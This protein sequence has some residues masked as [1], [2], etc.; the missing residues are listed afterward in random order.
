M[1]KMD[2]DS[3][4]SLNEVFPQ[5]TGSIEIPNKIPLNSTKLI[6]LQNSL[7]THVHSINTGFITDISKKHIY[8]D[9]P[10]IKLNDTNESKSL[11]FLDPK[12]DEIINIPKREIKSSTFWFED[13]PALVKTFDLLPQHDMDD[14][15]RL[16][17]MTRMIII[18]SVIMFLVQFQLW[19]FFLTLGLIVVISLW[20]LIKGREEIYRREYLQRPIVE[21]VN[22]IIQATNKVSQTLNIVSRI[23]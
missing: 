7:D 22:P 20:Q 5:Y 1:Y 21:P 18:I 10:V 9:I 6:D 8:G 13:P 12:W 23:P 15:E 17:A 19:W 3:K 4:T 14:T 11:I 16:N 2:T